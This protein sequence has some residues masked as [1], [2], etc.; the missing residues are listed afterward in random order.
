[1]ASRTKWWETKTTEIITQSDTMYAAWCDTGGIRVGIL[2]DMSMEVPPT[3]SLH[4]HV[5][6]GAYKAKAIAEEAF[7]TDEG[8]D[9]HDNLLME[10]IGTLQRA[11][12]PC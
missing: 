11:W 3:H 6:E 9:K 8:M 12:K 10:L 5:R 7:W 1:M 4:E 2:N